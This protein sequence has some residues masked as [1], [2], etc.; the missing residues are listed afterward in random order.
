MGPAGPGARRLGRAARTIAL[1]PLLVA[2]GAAPAHWPRGVV[3][4]VWIDPARAP[5]GADAL[6]ERAMAAWNTA[7]D[8]RFRLV[9]SMDRATAPVRV[10]FFTP[11]WRYG[12]TQARP[13]P[14]TGLLTEAE[15]VVA[16]GAAG[17]ALD[18]EIVVYL[19]ALHELG[20][21][22]GL[23][24]SDDARDIM[25]LFREPGDGARFFGA[26]RRRLRTA[27]DIGSPA[28]TGLSP[29]DV[30]QLRALYDD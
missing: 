28:A 3:I 12:M 11:D 4:R 1:A 30:L 26:Y 2:A 18:R 21:A 23:P 7:A 15:V 29:Q 10:R 8:G 16:A 17:D 13:D 19:T 27:D 14:A 24:H 25:Y 5:A 22:L 9:R 6:V 20:H